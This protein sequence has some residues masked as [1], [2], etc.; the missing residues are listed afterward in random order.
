LAIAVNFVN[1]RHIRRANN[2][3]ITENS[4]GQVT[5]PPFMARPHRLN[6]FGERPR[7]ANLELC[8]EGRKPD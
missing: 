7:V 3:T 5:P 2:A 8:D 1:T 6:K 4:Y